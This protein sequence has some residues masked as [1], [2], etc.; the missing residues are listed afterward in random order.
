[1]GF[2]FLGATCQFGLLA[3]REHRSIL[4]LNLAALTCNVTLTLLLAGRHGAVGAA[5][6][7]GVSEVFVGLTSA[8]LLHRRTGMRVTPTALARL[9]G[10]VLVGAAAAIL[11]STAG[12]VA[13]AL[14][15][16]A[17]ALATAIGLRALPVDL[18]A[19]LLRRGGAP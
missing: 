4:L 18:F 16:P 11:A 17:L 5:I 2:S 7:L 6:A 9:G 12:D 3:L 10:V 1:M 14:A 15:A 13:P 8:T 19:I